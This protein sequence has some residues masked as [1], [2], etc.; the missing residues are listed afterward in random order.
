[1]GGEKSQKLSPQSSQRPQESANRQP[2]SRQ[3]RYGGQ[4]DAKTAKV[5][6]K[7][8]ETTKDTKRTK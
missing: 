8:E 5:N 3:C 2:P 4:E 6:V 7:D 1:M